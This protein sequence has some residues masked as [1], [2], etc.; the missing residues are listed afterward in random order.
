MPRVPQEEGSWTS[1]YNGGFDAI[2][3]RIVFFSSASIKARSEST[4]NQHFRLKTAVNNRV[5]G[6]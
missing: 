1:M 5:I 3:R 4:K 6:G 2:P